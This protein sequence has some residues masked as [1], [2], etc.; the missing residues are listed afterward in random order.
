MCSRSKPPP[1]AICIS[2]P[3]LLSACSNFKRAYGGR[4][5][6]RATCA[7]L[8]PCPPLQLF[9]FLSFCRI[10]PPLCSSLHLTSCQLFG[11]PPCICLAYS[12]VHL[13]PGPPPCIIVTRTSREH[14]PASTR[15]LHVQ[16]ENAQTGA[17]GQ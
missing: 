3:L 12:R 15:T 5:C 13:P 6:L 11:L 8:P 16:P 17:H 10:S 1:A 4:M 9:F 7:S 14:A 2:V